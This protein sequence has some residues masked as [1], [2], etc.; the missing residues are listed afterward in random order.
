MLPLSLLSEDA[1]ETGN[2]TV[3]SPTKSAQKMAFFLM[4]NGLRSLL[5]HATLSTE[6]FQEIYPQ[7]TNSTIFLVIMI[8]GTIITIASFAVIL[9]Q[10]WMID[11]NKAEILSLYALLEMN[12]IN[13]VYQACSEHMTSLSRGSFFSQPADPLAAGAALEGQSQAGDLDQPGLSPLIFK[14]PAGAFN[15]EAFQQMAGLDKQRRWS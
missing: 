14:G 13:I 5:S 8:V 9:Y 7:R 1:L 12:E 6:Y 3:Q 15:E 4:V 2:F 11:Q 10:V